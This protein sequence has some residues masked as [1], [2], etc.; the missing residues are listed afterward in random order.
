MVSSQKSQET[1]LHVAAAVGHVH[2]VKKLVDKMDEH[3]LEIQNKIGNT[4]LSF[5]AATGN[6]RIAKYMV[7]KDPRLPSIRGP[8]AKSPLYFAALLEQ[9]D[10]VECGLEHCKKHPQLALARDPPMN[11]ETLLDVLARKPS[12]FPGGNQR[13]F[14]QTIINA[15]SFW[16]GA[17]NQK[18][19][20]TKSLELLE[21]LWDQ[22][23]QQEDMEISNITG[24][25]VPLLFVAAERGNDVFLVQLL[26]FY[27]DFMLQVNDKKQ[28]IFHI[29]VLNRHEHIFNLIYEIGSLK[30]LIATY[31]DPEDDNNILHLA[32]ML[33]PPNRINVVSGAALQ[34]QRELV[35]YKAVEKI[36]QPSYRDHK[37]KNLQ[38]PHD[39][40]M[41]EHKELMKE[42]EQWMKATANSCMPVATLIAIVVFTTSFTVPGGNDNTTGAPI[43]VNESFFTK[44][45]FSS[46]YPFG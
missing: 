10:M 36:F 26:R 28:S 39:L 37:N 4:A 22:V 18:L 35:W 27:P 42:G 13:G 1:A 29:A 25:N 8:Q 15:S 38:V 3:H 40:F 24:S 6:V 33:A 19:M 5:A 34:M 23:I 32:A 11:S 7:T 17:H 21:C 20:Q 14:W 9:R 44:M 12:A 45:I 16:E 41:A 2:F 46:H 30:E 31:R 43:L